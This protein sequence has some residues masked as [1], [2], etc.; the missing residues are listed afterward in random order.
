MERNGSGAW[1]NKE[2]GRS[3]RALAVLWPSVQGEPSLG[4]VGVVSHASREVHDE[5]GD[6]GAGEGREHDGGG[7]RTEDESAL[8][9]QWDLQSP[10]GR[11]SGEGAEQPKPKSLVAA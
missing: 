2:R 11:S 6:A 3:G 1:G 8:C 10:V 4:V 5:R 7:R 9:G